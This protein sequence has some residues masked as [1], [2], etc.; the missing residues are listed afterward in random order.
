MTA[1]TVHIIITISAAEKSREITKAI[2]IEEVETGLAKVSKEIIGELTKEVLDLLDEEI[3]RQVPGNW[4]NV[5]REKR[6][7]Q[8]EQGYTTYYRR[9]YKDEM[10]VRRKPLDEMMKLKPYERNSLKVQEI[11][12][13]LAANSTYRMA[14][15]NLSL[16]THTYYSANSIQRMVWR[17]G[18]QINQEEDYFE[19]TKAGE[20]ETDILYGESDGVWIHLQREEKSKAEVKVA[21]IYV[22]KKGI[23]KGR[24]KLINKLVMTQLGGS[25]S[26]WQEKLRELADAHYNLQ[27]V[28][29]LVTGGDGSTWVKQSFDLFDLPQT[30]VLDRFH[31]MRAL[32]QAFGRELSIQ[33]TSKLLFSEGFEPV[34]NK[35]LYCIAKA[36]GNQREHMIQVYKYLHNNQDALQDLHQRGY[37]NLS[38]GNLGTIE[39]N[40]N[41]LVVHRMEGRGCSW[42]ISGAKAMLAILRHKDA[43]QN[44]AFYYHPIPKSKKRINRVVPSEEVDLFPPQSGSLPIFK[45]NNLSVQWVQLLKKKLDDNLSLT[46]LY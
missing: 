41:K 27:K 28:K 25:T 32:R 3:R 16:L 15:Q 29:L 6:S 20:L 8:F 34:S 23:G 40:V 7:I 35:L 12:C 31:L 39:G 21:V 10:G 18:H 11:G 37:N 26:Q 30:H 22:G 46:A 9:I 38:F 24:Y 2:E 36:K 19:S 45:S 14:A 4:K 1:G 42:R 13:V 17:I 33:E 43:L 5:G 44:H